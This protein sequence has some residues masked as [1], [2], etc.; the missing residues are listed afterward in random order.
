M[1]SDKVEARDSSLT[2]EKKLMTYVE[3]AKYCGVH[4]RTIARWVD[5]L[6]MPA[7]KP[8]G[9]VRFNLDAVDKWLSKKSRSLR[10]VSRQG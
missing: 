2:S 9:V 3:V 1:N 10:N 6:G 8:G 4:E 5:K 7:I